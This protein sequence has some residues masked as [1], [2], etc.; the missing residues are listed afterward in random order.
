MRCFWLRLPYAFYWVQAAHGSRTRI[1]QLRSVHTVI[2]RRTENRRY[3]P[4]R[5]RCYRF[6]AVGGN[7]MMPTLTSRRAVI[8]TSMGLSSYSRRPSAMKF[9]WARGSAPVVLELR[10][11]AAAIG[12][13]RHAAQM[14]SRLYYF[15][16]QLHSASS[17]PPHSPM[18]PSASAALTSSYQ[19]EVSRNRNRRLHQRY[20][21]GAPLACR[22]PRC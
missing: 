20:A 6:A 16:A 9:S 7:A 3:W 5:R 2:S 22:G 4:L 15:F 11:G 1:A 14:T 17:A 19:H 21:I 13:A 18:A 8:I 10:Y 12:H